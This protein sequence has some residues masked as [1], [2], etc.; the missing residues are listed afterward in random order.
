MPNLEKNLPR[1]NTFK[2]LLL[3]VT[4]FKTEKVAA[5]GLAYARHA[6]NAPPLKK[7][8]AAGFASV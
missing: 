2:V 6:T 4:I 5:I 3:N 7:Q 8:N 1:Q